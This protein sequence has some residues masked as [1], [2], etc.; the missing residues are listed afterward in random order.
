[1]LEQIVWWQVCPYDYER[2]QF[3][4][5]Q[6]RDSTQSHEKVEPYTVCGGGRYTHTLSLSLSLDAAASPSSEG[7]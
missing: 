7:L 2:I 4:L 6:L 3:V 1:M 5:E